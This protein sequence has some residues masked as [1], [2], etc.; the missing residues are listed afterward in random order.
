MTFPMTTPAAVNT[1]A[2]MTAPSMAAVVFKMS[3]KVS[4]HFRSYFDVT[5][6]QIYLSCI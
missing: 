3:S 6:Y 1:L 5:K 2:K 4:M